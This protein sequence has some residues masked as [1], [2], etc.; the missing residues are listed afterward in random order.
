MRALLFLFLVT[1]LM[2]SEIPNHYRS[3]LFGAD[4]SKVFRAFP[5]SENQKFSVKRMAEDPGQG[6]VVYGIVYKKGVADSARLYFVDNRFALA[7]EYCY[8]GRT[9]FEE[10]LRTL[11]AR[12]G[13]FVGQEGSYWRRSDSFMVRVNFVRSQERALVSY[14]KEP[15]FS[16]LEKRLNPD[17]ASELKTIDQ[18]LENLSGKLRALDEKN[19]KK[20]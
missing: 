2:A 19:L 3:L 13:Q 10:T 20:P 6:V 4:T 7:T 12:F 15:L 9:Y 1:G 14:F 17:P 16:I 5:L 8:P 11:S 18:E